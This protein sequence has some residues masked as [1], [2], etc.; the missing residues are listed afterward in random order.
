VKSLAPSR[1]G[2]VDLAVAAVAT[3][4]NVVGAVSPDP[5]VAYDLAEGPP[6]L[7]AVSAVAGAALLARR[8]HPLAVFVLVTV[9]TT[10]VHLGHWHNGF[11]PLTLVLAAYALGAFGTVPAAVA[12]TAVFSGCLGL[13][14]ALSAPYFDSP[15]GLQAFAQVGAAGL[16][17]AAVARRHS[18]AV[19]AAERAA[20]L[21]REAARDA[22]RAALDERLRVARELIAAVSDAMTAITVQAAAAR[23]DKVPSEAL[24]TIERSGRAAAEDLRRLLRTLRRAGSATDDP[25]STAADG[26]LGSWRSGVL[27]VD[28]ALGGCV[29]LF[30]VL[31]SALPDPSMPAGYGDP[32][33]PALLPL[34]AVPGLALVVRRRYPIAALVAALGAL[35]IVGALGWQTGSLPGSVLIATYA[36]G[37]W[38]PVGR[39]LAALAGMWVTVIAVESA[40]LIPPDS[41][42]DGSLVRLSSSPSPG[43]QAW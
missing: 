41:P 23:R 11:L 4:F 28:L 3:V 10:V 22:E 16:L 42:D 36:L 13:L 15:I 14:F 17:G 34:V 32:V 12:G 20:R 18:G 7:V 40:D 35:G 8:R 5:A 27:P 1:D 19:S 21:V 25:T 38:A 24:A 31:A 6:V 39:G 30:N 37:A 43:S 2:A 29:A 9:V 33:P 26:P